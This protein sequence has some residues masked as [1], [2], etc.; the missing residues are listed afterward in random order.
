MP[1]YKDNERNTFYV[2]T[3]YTDYTGAKKQK[4]K[5]GFKLQRDA[6]EWE[7]NFLEKMQGTP[8][9]TFQALYDLYI[10]DMSHRLR[11]NSMAGKKNVFK[12]RILPYFKDKPVNTITP[13]DI[14]A[15]QN[16][17]ISIGYSD[18]YLDRI[19][20]MLTTIM[21]YAVKF[22]NLPVN[23][24]DR[25]GHMGKRTR[26]QN[27][28]TLDEFNQIIETVTDPTANIALKV[29]F[30]SGMRFGELLALTLSDIDF[31]NNTISIT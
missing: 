22:Y 30:Y 16:E 31:E 27:F 1:V 12:N 19:Q 7:R 20:N 15:W 21:N 17:Q 9:M 14:R 6:K 28:W 5:R 29:L 10:E 8:D 4:L 25:A 2:K 11:E 18:A 23:P 26:S 24:C 13:A 3:Y